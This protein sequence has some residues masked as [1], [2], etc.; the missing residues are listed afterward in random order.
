MEIQEAIKDLDRELSKMTPDEAVEALEALR[1]A[2]PA[3]ILLIKLSQ[4]KK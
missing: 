1:E 4:L 3:F 2:I